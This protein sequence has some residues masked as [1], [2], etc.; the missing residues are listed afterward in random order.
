MKVNK[1]NALISYD[2]LSLAFMK[3]KWFK[4]RHIDHTYLIDLCH[5]NA[6]SWE[7]N[8]RVAAKRYAAR[9][10]ISREN[11]HR[12]FFRSR[13]P[14]NNMAGTTKRIMVIFIPLLYY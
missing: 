3:S 4:I 13:N 1:K 9:A 14:A 8:I 2:K 7:R 5:L 6:N 12:T 10:L 11:A